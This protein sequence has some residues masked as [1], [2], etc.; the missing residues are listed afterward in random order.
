MAQ[1]KL[2][3]EE[4][5]FLADKVA[6]Y[7]YLELHDSPDGEVSVQ[8][9]APTPEYR[10]NIFK[11]IYFW[12]TVMLILPVIIVGGF[13]LMMGRVIAMFGGPEFFDALVEN[14]VPAEAESILTGAGVTYLDE[15][16]MLYEMRWYIGAGVFTFFLLIAGVLLMIA[17]LRDKKEVPS[18]K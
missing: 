2:T 3:P 15:F 12:I 8:K 17:L 10:R 14:G 4:Q 18:E 7:E 9:V 1:R 11:N 5:A 13:G 6:Q 16:L